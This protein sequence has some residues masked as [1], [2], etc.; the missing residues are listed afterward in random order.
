MKNFVFLLIFYTSVINAQSNEVTYFNK[1]YWHPD[2][3]QILSQAV[4]PID[5]GYLVLGGYGSLLYE[6]LYVMKIDLV[7]TLI[8]F[9]HIEEG[10][11]VGVVEDGKFVTATPDSNFVVTYSTK[12]PNNLREMNL[13]KFN[14]DGVILW[15][16]KYTDASSK[17]AR[18]VISILPIMDLLWQEYR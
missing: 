16:K 8:W 13:T 7:G 11:N 1:I 5:D 3:M 17:F 6:G 14:K 18:Q 12:K 9:K 2:T 4:R 10:P 15:K